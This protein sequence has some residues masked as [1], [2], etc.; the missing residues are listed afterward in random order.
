MFFWCS[1]RITK[2]TTDIEKHRI[3][4]IKASHLKKNLYADVRVV[5]FRKMLNIMSN[6]RNI[7][8][9]SPVTTAIL[10]ICFTEKRTMI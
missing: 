1:T 2:P 8:K 3:K 4:Q 9:T 5:I 7:S 10:N 6:E